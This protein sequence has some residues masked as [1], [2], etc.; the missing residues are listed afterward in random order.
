MPCVSS[1]VIR[2][3]RFLPVYGVRGSPSLESINARLLLSMGG[4]GGYFLKGFSAPP[5][6]L[7]SGLVIMC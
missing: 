3:P 7:S 4:F 6:L 1:S 2:L 5:L